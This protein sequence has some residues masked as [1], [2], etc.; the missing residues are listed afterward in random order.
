MLIGA[1]RL[2]DT[3]L[4]CN[5]RC[6]ICE[7]VSRS[8]RLSCVSNVRLSIRKGVPCTVRLSRITWLLI[9]KR[10]LERKRSLSICWIS[11]TVG[12]RILERKGSL[13]I[14]WISTT[15]GKRILECK[16]CLTVTYVRF[17]NTTYVRLLCRYRRP[18]C[19]W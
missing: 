8:V 7:R 6:L 9:S 14:R 18:I 17:L 4:S 2:S 19:K 5:K 12:K 16:R 15:V 11:T 13:S 10:I 3:W 1:R